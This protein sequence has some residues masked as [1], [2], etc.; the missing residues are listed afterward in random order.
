MFYIRPNEKIQLSLSSRKFKEKMPMLISNLERKKKSRS[1]FLNLVEVRQPCKISKAEFE[2][3]YDM[4]L[5]SFDEEGIWNAEVVFT[6]PGSFFLQMIFISIEDF[7]KSNVINIFG[8][9]KS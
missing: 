3:K 6:E 9:L 2:E 4:N 8:K 5:G 1:R 7:T